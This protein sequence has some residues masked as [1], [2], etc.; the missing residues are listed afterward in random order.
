MSKSKFNSFFAMQEHMLAGHPVTL[1][2][3]ML[4]FGQQSPNR[5]LTKIKRDGFLIGSRTIPM[6]TALHRINKYTICK[7]PEGLPY[8]EIHLT[9][10]WIKR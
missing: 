8:K 6:A 2:E 1:L 9:E 5:A 7:A 10:Y 4:L 3:A